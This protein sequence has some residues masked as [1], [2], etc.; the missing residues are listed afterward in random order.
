MATRICK[1]LVLTSTAA[2]IGTLCVWTFATR[3]DCRSQQISLGPG[4]YVSAQRSGFDGQLLL[5]DDLK[6][7]PH[8]G[9]NA[10][11]AVDDSR[12][13]PGIAVWSSSGGLIPGMAHPGWWTVYV[14]LLYPIGLFALPPTVWLLRRRKRA[15][16]GFPIGDDT[17]TG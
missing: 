10:Y 17:A 4:L 6:N 3:V 12:P 13:L 9:I 15:G 2:L 1:A 16:R 5:F 8:R 11:H 7:G 14:S